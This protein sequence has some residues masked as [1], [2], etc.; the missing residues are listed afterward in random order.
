MIGTSQTENT[1]NLTPQKAFTEYGDMVWKLAITRLKNTAAADDI[2]QEVFVRYIKSKPVFCNREHLKA[3][4]I[5]VTLNCVKKYVTCAYIKHFAPIEENINYLEQNQNDDVY[6][7]VLSLATKYRVVIHLY[8]YEN[9]SVSEVASVL[10]ISE[11]AVKQRLK[12]AREMLKE[13]MTGDDRYV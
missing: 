12:R 5:R 6:L 8:Y 7:A 3:W 2:L 9:L 1:Y 10:K 11:S 4:L 13:Y